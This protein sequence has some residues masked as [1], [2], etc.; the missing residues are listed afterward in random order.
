MHYLNKIDEMILSSSFSKE[1]ESVPGDAFGST[2]L[3]NFRYVK[4]VPA[5][6]RFVLA[7][8]NHVLISRS[9]IRR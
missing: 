5:K 3:P 4:N 8:R 2:T 9:A 7:I 1:A 6:T